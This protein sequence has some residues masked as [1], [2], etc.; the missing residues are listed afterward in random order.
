MGCDHMRHHYPYL[1]MLFH[2]RLL[3]PETY[4]KKILESLILSFFVSPFF[5]R[6]FGVLVTFSTYSSFLTHESSSPLLSLSTVCSPLQV[7]TAAMLFCTVEQEG[8]G[9]SQGAT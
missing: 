2:T 9:R 7:L 5:S 6:M 8:R 1:S 4:R 3:T